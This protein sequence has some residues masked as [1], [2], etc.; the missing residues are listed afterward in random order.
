MSGK[1]GSERKNGLRVIAVGLTLLAIALVWYGQILDQR[2]GLLIVLLSLSLYLV[3]FG[4]V[5]ALASASSGTER[6]SPVARTATASALISPRQSRSMARAPCSFRA[7]PSRLIYRP[8]AAICWSAVGAT[9]MCLS[10]RSRRTWTAFFSRLAWEEARRTS[11]ARPRLMGAA[12]TTFRALRDRR[13][14]RL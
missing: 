8:S 5:A 3:L 4:A 14:G 9:K 1:P 11:V 10:P 12:T 6:L 2:R 7:P 13:T